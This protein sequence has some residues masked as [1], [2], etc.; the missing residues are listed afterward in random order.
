MAEMKNGGE[1]HIKELSA[2]ENAP[3]KTYT[4]EAEEKIFEEINPLPQ[5]DFRMVFYILYVPQENPNGYRFVC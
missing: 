4:L 5:T 2:Q 3:R 1:I